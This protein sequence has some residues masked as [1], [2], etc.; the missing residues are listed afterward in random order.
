MV[1]RPARRAE[2]SGPE[3]VS[4]AAGSFKPTR[5]FL[6]LHSFWGEAPGHRVELQTQVVIASSSR[7]KAAAGGAVSAAS[8]P[9]RNHGGTPETR[10]QT[11]SPPRAQPLLRAFQMRFPAPLPSLPGPNRLKK[12]ASRLWQGVLGDARS[13]ESH[14]VSVAHPGFERVA[15]P[16]VPQSPEFVWARAAAGRTLSSPPSRRA[17]DLDRLTPPQIQVRTYL[18]ATPEARPTP[19][20]RAW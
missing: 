10:D 5:Q 2:R 7:V 8:S 14:A 20:T 1:P 19:A 13:L 6:P 12:S 15:Q 16:P 3:L 9:A 18:H 11:K 4:G 17:Q